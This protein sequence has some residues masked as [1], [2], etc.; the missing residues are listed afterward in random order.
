MGTRTSTFGTVEERTARRARDGNRKPAKCFRARYVAPD[1]TRPSRTFQTKDAARAWLDAERELIDLGMWTA[2]EARKAES[3]RMERLA[4]ANTLAA[5]AEHYFKDRRLRPSTLSEYRR[6]LSTHLRPLAAYRLDRL[7]RTEVRDWWDNLNPATPAVNASAWRFLRSL[8]RAAE[9]EELIERAPTLPRLAPAR[10]THTPTPATLDELDVITA[11]MPERMRL[12]VILAAWVGLRKGELLELRR[13]DLI[14]AEDGRLTG[15]LH[16]TRSVTQDTH[17]DHEDA[18]SCGR[19][20]GPTKTAAGNRV[21][22]IPEPFMSLVRE[23]VLAHAAEGDDGLLFP[24][25]RTDH[26]S[27]RYLSNAFVAARS[28]AGRNDLHFHDLRHTALTVAGQVGAT[29]ADLKHR[30]GHSSHAAMAIY[31]HGTV[32]RD[33]LIAERLG[34]LYKAH[35]AQ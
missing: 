6:L 2:P 35:R 18:C 8:L 7:T 11:A 26:M 1:M 28:A 33:G 24:G 17:P 10:V 12:M 5:Y 21:V 4:A 20:V 27:T 34:D 31:Q 14:R 16:V 25:E 23:H 13:S 22:T 29:A 32:E 9:A 15:R 30:A 3:L 19:V